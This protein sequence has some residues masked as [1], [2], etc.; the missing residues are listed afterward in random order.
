MEGVKWYRKAA[1]QGVAEAQYNLGLA[2]YYGEGAE[3]DHVEAVKWYRKAAEQGVVPAQ[4]NLGVAYGRGEGVDRDSVEAYAWIN[5]AASTYEDAKSLRTNIE[6]TMTAQQIAD[7]QKR[8]AE[9]GALILA[10]QA[11]K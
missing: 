9:L 3:E 5:L 1:E 2:Y 6:T 7:R 8:S 11:K 4:F 10:N